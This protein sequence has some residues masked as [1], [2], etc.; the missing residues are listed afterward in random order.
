MTEDWYE[1]LPTPGPAAWGYVYFK[2]LG[3]L[4]SL[5]LLR[6]QSVHS[7]QTT[8]SSALGPY[9]GMNRVVTGPEAAEENFHTSSHSPH[10]PPPNNIDS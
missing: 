5:N 3:D 6:Q 4:G 1:V 8:E 2:P 7:A 9:S 10:A